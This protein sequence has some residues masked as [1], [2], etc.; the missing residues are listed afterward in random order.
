MKHYNN[1]VYNKIGYNKKYDEALRLQQG[2]YD[3]FYDKILVV[4][5]HGVKASGRRNDSS[6]A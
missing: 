5:V 2:K 4:F 1:K 3:T 6:V